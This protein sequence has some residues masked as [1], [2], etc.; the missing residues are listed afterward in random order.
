M[1]AGE[2]HRRYEANRPAMDAAPEETGGPPRSPNGTLPQP[3]EIRSEPAATLPI[4]SMDDV[5]ATSEGYTPL[6]DMEQ[7]GGAMFSDGSGGT[8]YTSFP[9]ALYVAPPD[10]DEDY[11]D[12]S[13]TNGDDE[14]LEGTAAS[15][16][17]ND[18]HLDGTDFRSLADN[19]LSMLDRE[20]LSVVSQQ[21]TQ[22]E[23]DAMPFSLGADDKDIPPLNLKNDSDNVD[24]T[25]H[26][27]ISSELLVPIQ[28]KPLPVID[29]DAVRRVVQTIQLRNP[30]FEQNLRQW[31]NS[32][33][34]V[35][36]RK[37]APRWHPIIPPVPLS[38]FRK[39]TE[40]A[41]QAS[42]NLTRSASIAEAIHRLNILQYDGSE[43]TLRIHILGCDHVECGSGDDRIKAF[44]GPIVRWVGA[45]AE[46]PSHIHIDL[47]GP[48]IPL[49]ATTNSIDLIPKNRASLKECVQSAFLQCFVGVYEE[50]L[51]S[52]T[53]S[54]ASVPDLVIAFNAGVW[55]Y[56]EWKTTVENL[57]QRNLCVPVV[58]TAYTEQEAEDDYD[59]IEAIV[60]QLKEFDKTIRCEWEVEMNPF[61]SC[62]DRNS[63]MAIPGR[64][65]RENAAWQA[66]R[67]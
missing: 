16:I 7:T 4:V 47:I 36:P 51:N 22:S 9:G 25:D 23:E 35:T 43:R 50:F 17:S 32:Q 60:E 58:F 40:K 27:T 12:E 31:E 64:I 67:F 54:G 28:S 62:V 2:H 14:E 34:R 52:M 45:Y 41:A 48:N 15:S 19:A 57:I 66:W 26:F 46:A 8:F 33:K 56:D 37:V 30:K 24:E 49:P 42:A 11:Y 55:G 44:F 59:V 63:A 29:A 53:N 1:G 18:Q 39:Q 61:A 65:Y 38:A 10:E 13:F 6:H 21:H 5:W 3:A 20:Y